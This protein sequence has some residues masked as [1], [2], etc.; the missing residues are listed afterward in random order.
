MKHLLNT[1]AIVSWSEP[2]QIH[3]PKDK[4]CHCHLIAT[5]PT[6]SEAPTLTAC[7]YYGTKMSDIFCLS[8]CGISMHKLICDFD[9]EAFPL[10]FRHK[11]Q[12]VQRNKCSKR[13]SRLGEKQVIQKAYQQAFER[14]GEREC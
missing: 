4:D 12:Y 6:Q 13:Q 9:I 5:V 7:K 10:H 8:Y 1:R 3:S 14:C 2:W 11:R